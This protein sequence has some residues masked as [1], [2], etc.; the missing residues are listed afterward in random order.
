MQPEAVERKDAMQLLRELRL[1]HAR[2][3]EKV[4]ED[5]LA[6][7]IRVIDSS[8]DPNKHKKKALL[9][10]LRASVVRTRSSRGSESAGERSWRETITLAEK[11]CPFDLVV[12]ETE[13]LSRGQAVDFDE[14]LDRSEEEL[15]SVE[16]PFIRPE[17]WRDVTK[18]IIH[19]DNNITIVDKYF[20]LGMDYYSKLFGPFLDWIADSRIRELRLF[21][22]RRPSDTTMQDR[23][24]T[25][26][27]SVARLRK[28]HLRIKELKILIFCSADL[29][30]RY[31]STKTCGVELDYGFRLSTGRQTYKCDV[32][33]KAE[34]ASIC[35]EFLT[36]AG[37]QHTKL[38]RLVQP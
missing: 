32:L 17:D 36:A 4:P 26:V 3:I 8:P 27:D 28:S 9:E 31:L 11:V 6:Q 7:A 33:R 14:Y 5:W 24:D 1:D 18:P 30:K 37:G 22:G 29:H 20:D 12:S 35:A 23:L 10:K 19:S 16:K 15:G 38:W 25:V 21:V 34:V 2:Y 13:I